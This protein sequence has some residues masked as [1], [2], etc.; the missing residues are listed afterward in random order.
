MHDPTMPK[1]IPP[2]LERE[3]RIMLHEY[4]VRPAPIDVY[5]SIRDALEAEQLRSPRGASPAQSNGP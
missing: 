3:L 1:R 4:R 5:N 2:A